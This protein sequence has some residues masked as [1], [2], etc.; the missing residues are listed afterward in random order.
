MGDR[1][2]DFV[3]DPANAASSPDPG[4]QGKVSLDVLHRLCPGVYCVQLVID[5]GM[6]LRVEGEKCNEYRYKYHFYSLAGEAGFYG[7]CNRV[8]G[9]LFHEVKQW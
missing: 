5:F 4:V 1:L 3:G 9:W 8:V 7:D 6:K 2:L